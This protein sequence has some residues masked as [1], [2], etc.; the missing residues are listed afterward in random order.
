MEWED[1]L[2]LQGPLSTMVVVAG[3][4]GNLTVN[5]EEFQER[6]ERVA[7]ALA[8]LTEELRGQQI[9]EAVVVAGATEELAEAG[10]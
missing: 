9:P 6:E 7:V 4:Q 2:T 3:A 5:L 8:Q 10:L 1:S